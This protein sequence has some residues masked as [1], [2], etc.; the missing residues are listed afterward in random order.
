MWAP[1]LADN[2]ENVG[3]V[4]QTYIDRLNDFK[5]AIEKKDLKAIAQ[6]IEEANK[7]KKVLADKSESPVQEITK[8]VFNNLNNN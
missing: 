4:L 8:P 6:N 3:R 5:T 7:I 1:I 2:S